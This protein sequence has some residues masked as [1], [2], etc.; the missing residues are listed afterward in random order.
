MSKKVVCISCSLR[1]NSNSHMLLENFANGAKS[2]GNDVEIISLK[3]KK[4]NFCIG[5][6]KCQE[7]GK[8]VINDDANAIA[9]KVLNADVVA[10]ATPIYYYEMAGQMKTLLDRMNSMYPKDYKFRDIYFFGTA[11]DDSEHTFDG[12]L[13]GLDGWIECYDKAKLKGAVCCG[14]VIKAGEIKG[15]E[16]LQEAY[17]MGRI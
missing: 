15:K 2:K 5:C 8:C 4:I 12:A 11:E 9:E 7:L 13:K 1:E 17:E 3:G 10:F 16:K 14:G 6:L